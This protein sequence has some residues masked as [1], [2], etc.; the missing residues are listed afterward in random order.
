MNHDE[1][2]LLEADHYPFSQAPEA[3]DSLIDEVSWRGLDCAQKK[4]V[5]ELETLEARTSDALFESFEI[6]RDVG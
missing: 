6:D 4:R 3:F 1:E 5:T 2:L